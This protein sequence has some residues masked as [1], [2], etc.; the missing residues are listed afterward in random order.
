[1]LEKKKTQLGNGR[2]FHWVMCCDR[3]VSSQEF[4]RGRFL[5][6][7]NKHASLSPRCHCSCG[8]S[9]SPSGTFRLTVFHYFK[10]N[11][12]GLP[13]C[14]EVLIYTCISQPPLVRIFHNMKI[15]V[16]LLRRPRVHSHTSSA[17]SFLLTSSDVISRWNEEFGVF[18]ICIPLHP[19]LKQTKKKKALN[20]RISQNWQIKLLI[21]W[22][23]ICTMSQLTE[24][25]LLKKKKQ[26]LA[27]AS[28]TCMQRA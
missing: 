15:L 8:A 27:A 4:I 11:C 6:T 24:T 12:H 17:V 13:F 21:F 1:M 28:V 2:R 3:I 7:G 19:S 14:F 5:S 18:W 10:C 26:K 9:F 22:S 16:S 20:A 23:S 25:H